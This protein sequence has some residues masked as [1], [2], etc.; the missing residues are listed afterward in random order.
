[1]PRTPA[2]TQR[3]TEAARHQ[4][5]KLPGPEAY[6]TRRHIKIYQAKGVRVMLKNKLP[7]KRIESDE[8][9]LNHVDSTKPPQSGDELRVDSGKRP[10]SGIK[11][12]VG[13]LTE[14][15]VT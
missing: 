4:A 13:G 1:M 10:Q 9:M 11:L 8:I 14:V 7:N 3:Q 5:M 12:R 15:K 6:G 2:A